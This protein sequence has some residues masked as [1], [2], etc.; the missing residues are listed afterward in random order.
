MNLNE[1][2]FTGD[3]ETLLARWRESMEGFAKEDFLLHLVTVREDGLTILDACPTEADFQGWINGDDWQRVKIAMGAEVVV[4][5][6]GE[7]ATAIAR[8]PDV[9]VVRGRVPA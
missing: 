4:T 6:L 9:E 3:P 2:R 1:Y 5:R 7:V 8:E